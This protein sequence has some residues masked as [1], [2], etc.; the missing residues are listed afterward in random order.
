MVEPILIGIS[1]MWLPIALLNLGKGEPKGTGA[2]TGM[3]GALVLICAIIQAAVF[4]DPFIAG[5]LFVHGLF[6][7]SVSYA[8]LSGLED[9]RSVGNVSLTTAIVSAIYMVLA[10]KG[11]PV[12]A[13]GEQLIAKSNF[14]GLACAGYAVLT[15]MVWLNAYG[16]F[17][18]K[19]LAYSLMTWVVV[20]LWVPAFWLLAA[21][22]LPF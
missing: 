12:L 11:G 1:I 9:M 2:S 21:G 13:N 18:G 14:L 8:L 15:F 4:K 10:F 6:Y 19:P 3:V 5:L 16:K 7:C 22:K 20:G 17:S